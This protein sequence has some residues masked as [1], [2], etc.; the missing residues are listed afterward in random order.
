MNTAIIIPAR[1]SST[2]FP[3]KPLAQIKGKSM[4][5]RTWAVAK[6]VTHINDVYITTDDER[7]SD[8]AHHFG[9]KVLMTG[10]HCTNGTERVFEAVKKIEQSPDIII[11]LQGDAVLT[12]PWVIQSLVNKMQEDHTI[13]LATPAVKL[14][15]QQYDA[16]N[17]AKS[18]GEVGGTL[19]TFDHNYNALY[20]S[21]TMIPFLRDRNIS[22]PYVYRHIGLY[23]YRMTT[24]EKYLSLTPTHLEK[25]EKLEQ[26]R[27][28]E[29]GIPIKIVIVDY[30]GRTHGSVD[31][32][33]D[34]TRVEEIISKEGELVDF[35][36]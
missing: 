1:Y 36:E 27:A 26:L 16:M 14:N 4:I 11:N 22:E 12:P 30:R 21:K 19:V 24:L 17:T 2:R 29:H 9:A 32:P 5:Y 15:W 34:L 28:L 25:A 31:S 10:T 8:E 33:E 13:A 35:K 3:G 7:I 23:A 6:T 20:F 18:Q